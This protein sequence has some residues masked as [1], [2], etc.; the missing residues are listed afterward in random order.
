MGSKFTRRRFLKALGAGATY[1]ALTNAVGC[2][3]PSISPAPRERVWDFRSRPD[4]SP[5]AIE[6]TTT[7]AHD[8]TAPGYIFAALKE[9]IGDYGPMIIDDLGELVWYGKYGSARD[10]KMQYYKGRPVLTWWEGRVIQGHGIGEYV[11][12]DGSY[13]EIARV[14]AGNGFR[15]DLHEFLITPQDTALLTAYVPRRADLSPIGG[16]E[17][18]QVWDG[19]AQE[20]DIETGRV[21]FEWH[22]LEHVGIEESYAK[23]PDNPEHLYDY[24]HI[25]SIDVD[26]DDN[27]IVSS[28]NTWTVYKLERNSG[29]VLWRLGGKN[30]DFEMGQGTQSAFQ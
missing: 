5:A 22:S 7:Q 10:F 28:R 25:N 3:L 1:L 18:G 29:D 15:G 9:G 11:I 20:V 19:I 12:F 14:R 6:V 24:F 4:L 8:D 17:Y 30:S 13:R 21:L 2:A 27:L 26:H 23:Q 16:P